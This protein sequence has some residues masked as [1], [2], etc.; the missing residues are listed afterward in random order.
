MEIVSPTSQI[1][2]RYNELRTS[3]TYKGTESSAPTSHRT[4]CGIG[5]KWWCGLISHLVCNLI[6]FTRIFSCA[7]LDPCL[8]NPCQ[9]GG[10][11]ER[12]GDDFKCKCVTGF[13]G[14]QCEKGKKVNSYYCQVVR[15]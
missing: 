8:S 10:S 14:T 5:V 2:T 1:P 11:C 6:H 9:H 15:S 7:V 3:M 12:E 4:C 13:T